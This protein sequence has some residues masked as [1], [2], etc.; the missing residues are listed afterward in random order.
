MKKPRTLSNDNGRSG[1]ELARH[2]ARIEIVLEKLLTHF[3]EHPDPN[4]FK[5]QLVA[6]DRKAAAL[7]KMA[8]DAKLTARCLPPEWSDVIISEAQNSEPDIERFEYPK[9]HQDDL[10]DYFK[11]DPPNGKLGTA[12][13][14]VTIAPSGELHSKS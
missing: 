9:A 12:S 10:I 3:L 4:G 2:P 13:G 7:Y 5:A 14:M 8:L 6:V 11:L 1:R